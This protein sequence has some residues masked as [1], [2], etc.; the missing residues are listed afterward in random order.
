MNK[1]KLKIKCECGV[2]KNVLTINDFEDG[3]LSIESKGVVVEED[4]IKKI[5]K[6]LEEFLD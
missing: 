4:N 1:L 5:I 6:F 3:Q 2:C